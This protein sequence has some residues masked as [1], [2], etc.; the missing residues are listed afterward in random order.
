[1]KRRDRDWGRKEEWGLGEETYLG[2]EVLEDGGEVD[3]GSAAD[4]LGVLA[5]LEVARD[6]ADGELEAGLGRPRHRLGALWLAPA[7][8][9]TH[10]LPSFPSFRWDS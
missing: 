4:A 6:A 7:A 3:G 8:A 10:L 5:R 1:V 2:G 9:G